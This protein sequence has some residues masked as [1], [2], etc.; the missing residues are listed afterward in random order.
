M[1][2]KY[3]ILLT[4]TFFFLFNINFVFA[5]QLNIKSTKITLDKKSQIMSLTGSVEVADEKNNVLS[6]NFAN[7]D[8]AKDLIT[9]QGI[10]K[11]TTEEKYFIESSNVIFD[12]KNGRIYSGDTSKILDKDGNEIFLAEFNYSTKTNIFSSRG[13]IKLIDINNNE[14]FF[15]EIYI[16]EK[17][18][19]IIGSDV[20]SYFK[21]EDMKI[22]KNNEPRFFANTFS[23]NNNEGQFNK[24]VFTYCKQRKNEK[25]PPWQLRAKKIKHNSSKK[26][27]YY[28]SAILKVFNFPIF[29]FPRISHPDPTVKRRSG[30]L[31]P[32][33]SDSES[34]GLGVA[35]PYYWSISNSKDLTFTPKL[36]GRENPIFFGEYR[37]DFKNSYFILD[38]SYTKGYKESDIKKSKG[39][40]SH[41]F[42]KFIHKFTND[43][44]I[45]SNLE[46]RIERVS[47]DTYLKV[48][49]IETSLADQSINILE[50]SFNY[51]FF[52]DD[53]SFGI[54]VSA[55]ENITQEGNK[56]W[57]YLVPYV[58]FN[59]NLLYDEKFGLFDLSSDLQVRNFRVDKQTEFFI[60]DLNWR[61][62]KW[63][64][65]TGFENQLLGKLKSVNYQ[66]NNTGLYKTDGTT[67]EISGVLG[68]LSALK[69]F[70]KDVANNRTHFLTPK[71][72]LRYAPGHMRDLDKGR[73]SHSNLFDINKVDDIEVI[74][75]GL[76]A[77]YGLDYSRHLSSST[78]N[79]ERKEIS[80]TIGQVFS[81]EENSDLPSSSSLDQRFSDV[82][83]SLEYNATDNT[84]IQYN[85]A[86]DQNYKDLNF[87]EIGADFVRGNAKF[88]L[89]YLEEK[90][91]I[92]NDE[93][94][95]LGFDLNLSDSGKVS[96]NT[97]RN[98]LTN[99]AEFYNLSY[100]YINDCLKAGIVFRRE[101]YTDRDIE[102]ENSIFF[103]ITLAPLGEISSPKFSK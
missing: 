1:R 69:L 88:N 15:S 21:D 56:R 83:G 8:K 4:V 93:Y 28:D 45:D 46:F 17:Q 22:H 47:N 71:F 101:F 94:I 18:N 68:Y 35:V 57:E 85:F 41:F 90:N 84:L 36:Y 62:N 92:G 70:K 31:V 42:S 25:C 76:S 91:H 24:G 78:K 34:V 10:T 51:E 14:Y 77:S 59:K 3:L 43:E 40:R 63:V 53:T 49:D 26:T 9:T 11:I 52:E 12:N 27:I 97:K 98:L 44:N 95:K 5:E 81:D 13:E 38:T 20:K 33:I 50:S 2:N 37:Q 79:D 86:I 82:V 64:T 74:E 65:K 48:H 99:S 30:L 32:Q 89:S 75:N 29:Y 66:A 72:L 54:N 55:L 96:F 80:L 102:P 100:N 16:D 61:S 73:L 87:S 58:S 6:T 60:N 39:A 67:S 19:K 23:L 103:K 7:Y